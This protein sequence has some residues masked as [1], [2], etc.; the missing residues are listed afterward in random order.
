MRVWNATQ[1]HHQRIT[2][3]TVA[4]YWGEEASGQI[5]A[6][7]EGGGAK[8]TLAVFEQFVEKLCLLG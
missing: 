1:R 6:I 7:V 5:I 4:K 2:G 8:L 3:E